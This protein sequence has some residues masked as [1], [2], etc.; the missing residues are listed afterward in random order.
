VITRA[1]IL[2]SPGAKALPREDNTPRPRIVRHDV[3]R[4]RER[5]AQLLDQARME[6][7]TVLAEARIS[8]QE[9]KRLA[10]QRGFQEGQATALAQALRFHEAEAKRDQRALD[11]LTTMACALSERLLGAALKLDP[12]LITSLAQRVLDEARGARQVVLKANPEDANLLRQGLTVPMHVK[13]S[14]E[15]DPALERGE[16]RLCSEIGELDASLGSRLR[17]LTL[18]LKESLQ[19]EGRS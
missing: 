11:R 1:R 2:K 16:L 17:L 4:A 5:A 12:E 6:A 9:H 13:L 14:V 8:S 19:S 3:M 7:E 10:Y 18:A 15:P